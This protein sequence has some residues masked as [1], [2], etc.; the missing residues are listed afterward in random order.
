MGFGL[1]PYP[2]GDGV[3]SLPFIQMLLQPILLNPNCPN[4]L[5]IG[6]LLMPHREIDDC[7]LG[8]RVAIA[9]HSPDLVPG[10]LP[11][12]GLMTYMV[13]RI[14]SSRWVK[15]AISL[16]GT[17]QIFSSGQPHSETDC[18]RHVSVIMGHQLG[19]SRFHMASAEIET[20]TGSVGG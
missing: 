17:C 8:C 14:S 4:P 6:R 18:D 3:M 10:R 13:V 1:C 11:V 15:A 7:G 2:K 20:K 16:S 9:P 5:M 19:L 12:P